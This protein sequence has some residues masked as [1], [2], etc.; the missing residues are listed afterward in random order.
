MRFKVVNY[1]S[2]RNTQFFNQKE[3]PFIQDTRLYPVDFVFPRS[4]K[5][6]VG[7]E[8]PEGYIAEFVPEK[9]MV[10]F[11]DGEASFSYLIKQTKTMK[12]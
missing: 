1:K 3:N 10:S 11:N 4:N 12:F 8:L 9:A 2:N 6:T 5:I 7:F